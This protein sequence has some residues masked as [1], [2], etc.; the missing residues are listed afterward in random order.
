MPHGQ[1]PCIIQGMS[2]VTSST[3]EGNSKKTCLIIGAGPAGLSAALELLRSGGAVRPIVFEAAPQPG[4]ISRTV[5]YKGNRIDIGGHRFF[6]KSKWVTDFWASLMDMPRRSRLSR[7]YYLRRFFNYPVSLS[8]DTLR[9]L[10]PVRTL[11]VGL[12]YLRARIAPIR[13]EK[14]LEDFMVNRFGRE[15]YKTFFRDYTQKVW[16]VPCDKISPEW[17]AQRIKGVSIG[18]VLAHALRSALHIRAKEQETSLI[19]AFHYPPHGP[20]ELWEKA[21][22]EV[23]R[24]GGKLHLNTKVQKIRRADNGWALELRGADGLSY[25]AEGDYLISTMPV[26]E[27]VASLEGVNV[28]ESVRE[29]AAGLVYRDFITVGLLVPRFAEAAL[30]ASGGVLRDNWIYIQESDVKLGRVQVFP[31]WSAE[32]VADPS[33]VWLGL[34]YFCNEGDEL[35]RLSDAE[36]RKLGAV[37][38]AKIGFIDEG[39]VLDSCVIRQPKAYPAYFGTYERIGELQ[40]YLDTLPG[41]VCAGRNGMHRYN[42]MDHSMLAAREAVRLILSGNAADPAARKALWAI[43]AEKDYHET[44]GKDRNKD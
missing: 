33:L 27:L 25:E 30:R 1:R 8:I 9:K 19:D 39:S 35:D 26:K 23:L 12:S 22:E 14:T 17:G 41:L 42:N 36:L 16:G 21:A 18:A 5:V 20:G 40:D 34:E 43:N 29:V 6:S 24:L 10:G 28:P 4:G 3:H 44:E 2:D 13:P 11:K 31:N 7:I 38:M 37:E 15:L 32:M